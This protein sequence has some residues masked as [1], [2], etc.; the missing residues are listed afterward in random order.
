MRSMRLSIRV[1]NSEKVNDELVNNQVKL[2]PSSIKLHMLY[3]R[4]VDFAAFLV[5]TFNTHMR[6]NEQ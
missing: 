3:H 2:L 1:Q 5:N 4:Y 6:G